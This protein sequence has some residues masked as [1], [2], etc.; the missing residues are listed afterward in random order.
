MKSNLRCWNACPPYCIPSRENDGLTRH[1]SYHWL[2]KVSSILAVKTRF[3]SSFSLSDDMMVFEH[4]K[5]VSIK[6][7]CYKKRDTTTTG[8]R[9]EIHRDVFD[10][11]S[12]SSLLFCRKISAL[13]CYHFWYYKV[14]YFQKVF[15]LDLI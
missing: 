14:K 5:N 12:N 4:W 7:N 15:R 6:N 8:R 10:H 3:L 9:V 2:M 13:Q 11:F 1:A